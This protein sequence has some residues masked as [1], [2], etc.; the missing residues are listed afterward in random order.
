M[1]YSFDDVAHCNM[2]RAPAETQRVLGKR[3]NRSQGRRPRRRI[4]IT[5]SVVRCGACGLIFSNPLPLPADLQDHYGVPPDHYWTPAYFTV[6]PHYLAD[7]IA[8]FRSLT[9]TAVGKDRLM[10]LDIGAGIGKGMIALRAAGF[11][12]YG[13]EPSEPFYRMAIDKMGIAPE[14]LQRAGIEDANFGAAAF[15][16]ITFSAVLEH[17]PDPAAALEKALSLLK[18]NGLIHVEV[19]SAAWLI[20]KIGNLFY[21]VFGSD[22][23]VNLSPMHPPYHLYE[24]TL[25]AFER[26]G[27][28]HGFRVRFHRYYVCQ[29]YL[30]RPIGALLGRVMGATGTGMQL[31]V[32]LSRADAR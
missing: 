18:P 17:L 6:D 9:G 30:P 5:T 32:W 25:S 16:F 11:D 23:V 7:Q 3:L 20:G 21:R 4:G 10:A 2:C 15:D 14:T 19:P 13:I 1:K 12:A 27:L 31:E 24:F 29:T 26:H 8:R 28:A 22:Y